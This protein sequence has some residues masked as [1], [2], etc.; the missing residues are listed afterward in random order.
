MWYR[1]VFLTSTKTNTFIRQI[2]GGVSEVLDASQTLGFWLF[3]ICQPTKECYQNIVPDGAGTG[4]LRNR[5]SGLTNCCH[6]SSHD[7]DQQWNALAVRLADL[8]QIE[9]LKTGV[10]GD[11]RALFYVV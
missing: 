3:L 4:R 8:C 10:S 7:I 9:D 2:Q 11:R 6:F 5:Y 1:L